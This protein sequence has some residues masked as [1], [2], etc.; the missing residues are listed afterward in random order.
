MTP[1]DSSQV[2]LLHSLG[3]KPMAV[4]FRSSGIGSAA[5][6]RELNE[7]YRVVGGSKWKLSKVLQALYEK[8]L[9]STSWD[10]LYKYIRK[11]GYY[12][13]QAQL[14]VTAE[15]ITLLQEVGL[16]WTGIL[17]DAVTG[18]PTWGIP[19]H[20]EDRPSTTAKSTRKTHSRTRGTPV[21]RY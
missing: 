4:S 14:F 1:L 21:R 13:Y 5:R 8:G 7:E 20:P 9:V 11:N 2:K 6:Y 17:A 15:G 19:V 18:N 16:E 10:D 12:D 3:S